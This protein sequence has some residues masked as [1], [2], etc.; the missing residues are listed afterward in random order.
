[1]SKRGLDQSEVSP[2]SLTRLWTNWTLGLWP[3]SDELE[4]K[5]SDLEMEGRL[6]ILREKDLDLRVFCSCNHKNFWMY[7]INLDF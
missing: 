3:A 4:D 5:V 2:P 6:L 7:I 1:M